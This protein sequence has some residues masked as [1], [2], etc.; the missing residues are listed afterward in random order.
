MPHQKSRPA[1]ALV[2]FFTS[3]NFSTYHKARTP[4]I[5]PRATGLG[6]ESCLNIANGALLAQVV[7]SS[8]A[9]RGQINPW[10]T[11]TK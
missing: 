10:Q 5:S 11:K 6:V 3:H 7:S 2:G 8:A 1:P 9:E 4:H